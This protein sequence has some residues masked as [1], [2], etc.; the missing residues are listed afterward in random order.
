MYVLTCTTLP[1]VHTTGARHGNAMAKKLASAIQ[2]IAKE[3]GLQA[4]LKMLQPV[5]SNEVF[6]ALP[7]HVLSGVFADGHACLDIGALSSSK[8]PG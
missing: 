3:A 7:E 4:T 1:M 8:R 2:A 5:Q 6:F